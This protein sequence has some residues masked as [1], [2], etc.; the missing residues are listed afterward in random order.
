[1]LYYRYLMKSELAAIVVANFAVLACLAVE[2]EMPSL[3]SGTLPNTEVS[4]NVSLQ[5]CRPEIQQEF[6]LRLQVGNCSSNEV[7]VAIGHDADC[8]GDLSFDET[9]LVF[10][11]DCG[12]R[13]LVDYATQRVFDGI[14]D[15]IRIKHRRFNPAWDIAK[16]VKRGEGDMGETITVSVENKAFL[17]RLQ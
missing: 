1:M 8:D 4:T 5:A 3:Q 7:L 13:Y 2:Y 6:S 16:A 11:Y 12:E 14:G 9:D 17:I 15:T 10:G